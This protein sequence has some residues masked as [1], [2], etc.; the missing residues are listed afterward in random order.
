MK[1]WLPLLTLGTLLLLASSADAR[2]RYQRGRALFRYYCGSCLNM[3]WTWAPENLD[4]TKRPPLQEMAKR[5]KPARICTWLRKRSK[6]TQGPAC[7]PGRVR[8][9]ARL[10]M[11]YYLYRRAR[12]DLTLAR[13]VRSTTFRRYRGPG[14][15]STLKARRETVL[16]RNAN[17]A[18]LRRMRQQSRQ[19]TGRRTP[20]VVTPRRTKVKRTRSQ[21]RRTGR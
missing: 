4:P 14:F 2:G 13:F 1:K 17:Q 20:Q 3:G 12:G 10:D 18:L 11:L 6:R 5:W 19:R 8:K 21:H 16:K 7:Y 15:R 9:S